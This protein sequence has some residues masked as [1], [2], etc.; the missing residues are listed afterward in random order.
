MDTPLKLS[1]REWLIAGGLVLLALVPSIAGGVRIGE[2]ATG[3]P[4]T[5]QNARFLQTPLPVVMHIVGALVYSIVGAFQLLPTIA[6]RHPRWHRFAGRFLLVPAGLVV[7]GSGLW[8]TAAYQM[9]PIDGAALALS[10]YVIGGLMLIFIVLGI[11]AI[12]RRDVAAHRA[13]M[14]RAYALAMGAGT[15]V[16]TSGPALLLFGEPDTFWRVVQMDAGW[17]LNAVMAEWIIARRR[18]ATR[19]HRSAM[20]PA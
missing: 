2:I 13:W 12:A 8:M 20:A 4:E 11:A 14:I 18:A 10:R 3:A 6:R 16:L 17:L 5:S 1:R 9:P 7:A 15:Q 19:R